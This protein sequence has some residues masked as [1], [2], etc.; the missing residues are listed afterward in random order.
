MKMFDEEVLELHELFDGLVEN[1][2]SINTK[3]KVAVSLGKLRGCQGSIRFVHGYVLQ[4]EA[5]C[6][7][8]GQR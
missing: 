8:V 6:R 3:G 5:L 1:N 4:F 7:R 2:L